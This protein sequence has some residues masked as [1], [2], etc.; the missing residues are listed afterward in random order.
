MRGLLVV[1]AIAA[2]ACATGAAPLSPRFVT[3]F[4]QR[5]AVCEIDVVRDLRSTACFVGFRCGRHAAQMI[6][7]APDVC[8]P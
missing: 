6:A 4:E 2:S 8:I 5:T 1:V 3:V 7:V